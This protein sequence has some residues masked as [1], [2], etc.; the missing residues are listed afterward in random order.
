MNI[1]I[2]F[3][4][5]RPLLFV[6]RCMEKLKLPPF[7]FER[8]IEGKILIVEKDFMFWEL[9]PKEK[10]FIAALKESGNNVYLIVRNSSA[11]GTRDEYLYFPDHF[12]K[13]DLCPVTNVDENDNLY[14][15][16]SCYIDENEELV[17]REVVVLSDGNKFEII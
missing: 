4:E 7:V 15:V 14:N 10:K 13:N 11:D 3:S 2:S 9:P 6:K 17:F 8:Y 5:S 1:A 12:V 16:A